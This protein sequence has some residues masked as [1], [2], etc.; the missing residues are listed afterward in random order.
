MGFFSR[1]NSRRSRG[2]LRIQREL[3]LVPPSNWKGNPVPKHRD[4]A[5]PG[6]VQFPERWFKFL[7]FKFRWRLVLTS[8]SVKRTVVSWQ[9][10][11]AR[12]VG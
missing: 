2:I 3:E 9:L 10:A 4:V 11:I 6:S 8:I 5:Q 7:L 1:K 12:Q